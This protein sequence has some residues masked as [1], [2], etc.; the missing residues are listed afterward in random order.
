MGLALDEPQASENITKV[1]GVDLLIGDEVK[2]YADLST[3]DYITGPYGE[4]FSVA[5]EG[6]SDC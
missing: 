3:I 2:N 5:I 1:D 4:G 6:A